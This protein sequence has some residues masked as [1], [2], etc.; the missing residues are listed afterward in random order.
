[1]LP[2]LGLPVLALLALGVGVEDAGGFVEASEFG[3]VLAAAGAES[4]AAGAADLF[5]AAFAGVESAG[6]GE[7]ASFTFEFAVEAAGLLPGLSQPNA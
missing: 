1:M 7:P 4:V 5:A 2:E 6:A 3:F